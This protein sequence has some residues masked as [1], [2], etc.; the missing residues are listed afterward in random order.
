MGGIIVHSHILGKKLQQFQIDID[1]R[2]HQ[3]DMIWTLIRS[4]SQFELFG[5][6]HQNCPFYNLTI[7]CA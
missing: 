6:P 1:D 3:L 4:D 7:A 5:D 2:K